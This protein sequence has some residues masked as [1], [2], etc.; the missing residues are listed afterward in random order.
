MLSVELVKIGGSG[1]DCCIVLRLPWLAVGRAG[2]RQRALLLDA[3]ANAARH[4]IKQKRFRVGDF[5]GV[6]GINAVAHAQDETAEDEKAED[7]KAED[8]LY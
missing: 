6:K 4:R 3:V 7:E 5:G 8:E 2:G 1:R